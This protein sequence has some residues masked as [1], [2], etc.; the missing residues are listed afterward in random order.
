MNKYEITDR[1]SIKSE[2]IVRECVCENI[3]FT[4]WNTPHTAEEI[5]GFSVIQL[6]KLKYWNQGLQT[7]I[8]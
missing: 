1:I 8:I 6:L 5:E 2:C 7:Y 3:I 4:N